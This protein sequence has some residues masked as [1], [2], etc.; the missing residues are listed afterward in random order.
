MNNT[1]PSS[2]V[3]SGEGGESEQR[4][5]LRV[6]TRGAL[7][8]LWVSMAA[9]VPPLHPKAVVAHFATIFLLCTVFP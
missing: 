1:G 8:P 9:V 5:W 2:S 7:A 4:L 6:E 3:G